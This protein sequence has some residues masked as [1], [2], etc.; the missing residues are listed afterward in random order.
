MT[1][2]STGP[3]KALA[4]RGVELVSLVPQ[5]RVPRRIGEQLLEV[6]VSQIMDAIEALQVHAISNEFQ[7]IE[8]QLISHE[9]IQECVMELPVDVVGLPIKSEIVDA[10]QQ[11]LPQ[12]H[13]QER[14][15]KQGVDIPVPLAMEEQTAE[16][17]VRQPRGE[18]VENEH[19]SVLTS[20]MN[21]SFVKRPSR[22]SRK[23]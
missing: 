17:S 16:Q 5:E 19:N 12:E 4:F 1:K 8:A 13:I 14:I 2:V 10:V 22:C 21:F 23:C 15:V 20:N 3:R 9:R 11:P 18:T 6:P 7:T